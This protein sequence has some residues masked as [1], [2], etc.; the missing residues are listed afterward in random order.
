MG[1]PYWR[2]VDDA[3][4]RFRRVCGCISHPICTQISGKYLLLGIA[5]KDEDARVG[6]AICHHLR[7]QMTRCPK[8]G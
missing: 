1:F 6:I 7:H 5:G 8:P 2:G 3:A 4:Q